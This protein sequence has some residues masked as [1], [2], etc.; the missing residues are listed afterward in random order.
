MSKSGCASA[1]RGVERA[2]AGH[3]AGDVGPWEAQPRR[4]API[5]TDHIHS[6]HTADRLMCENP[7]Q[8]PHESGNKFLSPNFLINNDD[9]CRSAY[10]SVNTMRNNGF[11]RNK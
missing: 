9:S 4:D 8:P 5:F 10:L 3:A 2:P 11:P 7:I 6:D 1:G